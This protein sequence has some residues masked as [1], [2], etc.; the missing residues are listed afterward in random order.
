[1]LLGFD[2]FYCM[3]GILW[4]KQDLLRTA[5]FSCSLRRQMPDV[6]GGA[7]AEGG[8]TDKGTMRYQ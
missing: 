1:M 2:L 6:P 4:I 7:D 3:V 5:G 8:L